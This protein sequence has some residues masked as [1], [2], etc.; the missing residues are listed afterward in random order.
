MIILCGIMNFKTKLVLW[1]NLTNHQNSKC[2]NFSKIINAFSNYDYRQ[3][4][5]IRCT[6]S[7]LYIWVINNFIASKG[8]Y[9]IRDLTVIICRGKGINHQHDST[10]TSW[11]DWFQDFS[12]KFIKPGDFVYSNRFIKDLLGPLTIKSGC[13]CQTIAKT[14]TG[15]VQDCSISY[16]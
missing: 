5:N 12:Q 15:I 7:Q 1:Y 16:C 14:L 13:N 9:Y 3:I 4:S 11:Y 2:M 6:K 8:A 10:V